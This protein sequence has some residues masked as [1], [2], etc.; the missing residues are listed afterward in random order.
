MA[1]PTLSWSVQPNTTASIDTAGNFTASSAG[2]YIIT[3]QG[4][5]V[6]GSAT[7]SVEGPIVSPSQPPVLT[8]LSPVYVTAG[9]SGF[10]LTVSGT[11]FVQGSSITFNG[12]SRMTTYTSATQLQAA[13]SAADIASI[14]TA[15]IAAINPGSSSSNILTLGIVL[16]PQVPVL[17]LPEF[18]PVNAVIQFTD[19]L[20]ASF[21]WTLNSQSVSSGL[22]SESSAELTTG[23]NFSEATPSPAL[24]LA[25][26]GVSPG[27]Y[28]IQV[29]AVNKAGQASAPGTATVTLVGTDLNAVRVYPNPWRS[30][31]HEGLP[32]TFDH[33]TLGSTIKLFDMAGRWVKTLTPSS[34]S[35][36]WD[37][38]NDSGDTV[39]SGLYLYLVTD[40][41]GNKTRGKLSIIK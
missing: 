31:R 7:V 41:Q 29:V 22:R 12:S 33:L 20:D 16:P 34:D 9:D 30:D 17:N 25:P 38:T 13:I 18:L 4:D 37:R 40:N 19:S 15:D 23:S 26:L 3:V 21:Q 28:T 1:P 5:G 24:S 11:G 14:G 32:I 39:A 27:P 35:V 6:V 8:S 10:M 36:T 2:V